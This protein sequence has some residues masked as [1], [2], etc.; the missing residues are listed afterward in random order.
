M[1]ARV[2]P[3]PASPRG[4]CMLACRYLLVEQSQTAL[5]LCV[6]AHNA[7]YGHVSAEVLAR[8]VDAHVGEELVDVLTRA[9]ELR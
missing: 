5:E 1:L 7:R 9:Q 8:L 6:E 3:M 2:N 4:P